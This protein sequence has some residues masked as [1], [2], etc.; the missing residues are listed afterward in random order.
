M[1]KGTMY[2]VWGYLHMH[3]CWVS[4]LKIFFFEFFR[5][6]V[7]TQFTGFEFLRLCCQISKGFSQFSVYLSMF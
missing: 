4:R 6:F 2:D 3:V 1:C 7:S 5:V